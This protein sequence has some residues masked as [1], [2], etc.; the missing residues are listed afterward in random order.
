M[1]RGGDSDLGFRNLVRRIQS[2]AP[3]SGQSVREDMGTRRYPIQVR[4]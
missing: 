3:Q 4:F 1:I 2:L